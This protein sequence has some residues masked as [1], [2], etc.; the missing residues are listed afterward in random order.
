MS[1]KEGV[2]CPIVSD[3]YELCHPVCA[4]DFAVM[5]DR[6][7]GTRRSQFWTPISM[8][9]ITTSDL[10]RKLSVSDSPWLASYALIFRDRVVDSIG[11]YLLRYGE[12][13]PLICPNAGLWVLNPLVVV[14]AIDEAASTV[15]RLP[16]GK[17]HT[18]NRHVFRPK[19]VEGL[20]I[21]RRFNYLCG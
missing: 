16:S 13:L 9:I 14:D 12:L 4:S 19:I 18:I 15:M 1:T 3:D 10:G 6:I 20:E 11:D 7:D 8:E 17:I 5:R 2:Y 21:F